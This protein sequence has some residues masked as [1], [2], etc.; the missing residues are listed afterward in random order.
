MPHVAALRQ[1]CSCG[2]SAM[3]ET[4]VA[5]R[6]AAA[7]ESVLFLLHQ[8]CSALLL[9]FTRHA[10]AISLAFAPS[11]AAAASA[12][13]EE[14]VS[15]YAARKANVAA[16]ETA[17]W[18]EELALHAPDAAVAE[19]SV[20]QQRQLEWRFR[21]NPAGWATVMAHYKFPFVPAEPAAKLK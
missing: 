1:R 7:V 21:E 18:D 13:K 19:T 15:D 2:A 6:S 20:L 16:A 3:A 5:R 8:A 10:P 11:L 12:G 17:L 9:R 14:K 4:A